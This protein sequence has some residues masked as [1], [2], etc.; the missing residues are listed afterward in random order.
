[1]PLGAVYRDMWSLLAFLLVPALTYAQDAAPAFEVASVKINN[2]GPEAP[3][4]FFPA[5]GRLRVTN[6]TLLQLIQAAYHIKTGML[7]GTA[8]W[9]ESERFDID[10]KATGKSSF[11]EDMVMLR[12]VLGDQF[13]LRFHRET[14]LLKMQVLVLGKGGPKFQ[15]SKDQ[16]QKERVNIRATEISGVAIPFGHFVTILEA[17]LGYPIINQ[18]GLSGKYDL[19]LK[20]VRAD[21]PGVDGPSVFAALED[22]GLKLETRKAPAEVFVI[23][24]AERPRDN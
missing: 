10:A 6:T 18:T 2:S 21:S 4:G 9:M 11:D 15:A 23:D 7:F 16:D 1:L 17:Q 19:A 13:Q 5:P 8:A 14:R 22:L 3:N 24:S 12:A 20:Y